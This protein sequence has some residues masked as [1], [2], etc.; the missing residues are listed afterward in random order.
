MAR[1]A[2]ARG[3]RA[4][5]IGDPLAY[6]AFCGTAA[7]WFEVGGDLRGACMLRV[8]AGCV[9]TE[10]GAYE[11][12][13]VALRGALEV[14]ER[15][16]L[17]AVAAGAKNN[18]G[19]ALARQG[20]LDEAITIERQTIADSLTL[21]FRRLEAASRM[22]L[23]SMLALRGDTENAAREASAA[24]E[25]TPEMSPIRAQ[26]L[27][28]EAQV[29]LASGKLADAVR[30]ATSA[31]QMLEALG[32]VD[33]GESQIR[34]VYAEVLH[35]SNRLDEARAVIRSAKERVLAKA[36]KITDPTR[37]QKFLERV[38]E[39]ARTVALAAA[40]SA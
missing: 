37:R 12:A 17:R 36:D 9:S 25:M 38:P 8:N 28:T 29:L 10:I 1:L 13:E 2:E 6:I 32:G 26:A 31:F 3:T 33:E 14:A 39:N 18:L 22:Y 27:A 16:N 23:A 34:V 21:G 30:P 4:L 20:R 7:G 15:T 24:V 19:M 35:A 40:W 5:F 11:E